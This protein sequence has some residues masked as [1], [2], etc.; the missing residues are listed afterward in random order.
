ML[1]VF[2]P[3]SEHL[4]DA[5]GHSASVSV[6]TVGPFVWRE[7]GRQWRRTSSSTE[8]GTEVGASGALPSDYE[9]LAMTCTHP[10]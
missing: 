9:L 1:I 2:V 6:E 3:E 4:H 8:V 10:R 7:G 5:K